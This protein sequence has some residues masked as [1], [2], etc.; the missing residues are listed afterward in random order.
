MNN[1]NNDSMPQNKAVSE[2]V[3]KFSKLIISKLDSASKNGNLS[4]LNKEEHKAELQLIQ[5]P[6]RSGALYG[7]GAG[8]ASFVVL[9]RFPLAL[10]RFMGRNKKNTS[11]WPGA[12]SSNINNPFHNNTS[13]YGNLRGGD[14][15]DPMQRSIRSILGFF[16]LA[17]DL[18]LSTFTAFTVSLTM[19]DKPELLSAF[20]DTPLVEGRSIISDELC[21]DSIKLYNSYPKELWSDQTLRDQSQASTNMV[22]TLQAFVRNCQMRGAFED[23]LRKDRGFAMNAPVSIPSPGV[24]RD[25]AI[26]LHGEENILTE[27]EYLVENTFNDESTFQS[28]DS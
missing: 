19:M 18:G 7:L 5:K 10:A 8:I 17:F 4:H 20:S 2:A 21:E 6:F 24:P 25:T 11:T 3:L 22:V 13:G 26:L 9:R 14:A 12:P 16:G 15:V 28:E 1:G 23:E 27:D